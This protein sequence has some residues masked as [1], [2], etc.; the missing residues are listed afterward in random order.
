M[1][2]RQSLSPGWCS[3][4]LLEGQAF[5]SHSRS[6]QDHR[7]VLDAASYNP[8]MRVF[9]S[10]CNPY[11]YSPSCRLKTTKRASQGMFEARCPL[12]EHGT[13]AR[14]EIQAAASS[15][16]VSRSSSSSTGQRH[17]KEGLVSPGQPHPHLLLPDRP[18]KGEGRWVTVWE[19]LLGW[20]AAGSWHTA[21][22]VRP[23]VR[24]HQM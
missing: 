23:W 4:L 11:I 9:I 17:S 15:Q 14:V 13:R 20:D 24:K 8:E 5:L 12:Q 18:D 2:G 7:S 10:I 19:P 21:R 16:S 22:R 1:V 6:L 3:G